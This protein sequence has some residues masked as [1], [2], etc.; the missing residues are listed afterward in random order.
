M[1]ICSSANIL[2]LLN[3][4]FGAWFTGSHNKGL[5][6]TGASLPYRLPMF[7]MYSLR[8]LTSETRPR[9]CRLI[10]NSSWKYVGSQLITTTVPTVVPVFPATQAHAAGLTVIS[11]HGN[12]ED[13]C[14]PLADLP[15]RHSLG[16]PERRAF[17]LKTWGSLHLNNDTGDIRAAFLSALDHS[18]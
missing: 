12:D 3:N 9:S 11:L 5:R 8:N 18:F 13:F 14:S 16:P 1:G 2:S 6:T 10:R 15:R 17:P 4:R 7:S